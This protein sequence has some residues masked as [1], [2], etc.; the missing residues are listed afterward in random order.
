MAAAGRRET[1]PH[2]DPAESPY[3]LVQH[4]VGDS[5]CSAPPDSR[6]EWRRQPD[7]E[8]RM[9]TAERPRSDARHRPDSPSGC[10]TRPCD[11]RTSSPSSCS[12]W[13]LAMLVLVT[14]LECPWLGRASS[15]AVRGWRQG[16]RSNRAALQGHRRTG[17]Y[18]QLS[19]SLMLVGI[20]FGL[21][22]TILLRMIQPACCS[23][24]TK[25]FWR[26]EAGC[27]RPAPLR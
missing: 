16:R 22:Q 12:R 1:R 11:L 8:D 23:R 17:R 24:N 5:E 25:P 13:G 6:P 19:R 7:R 4:T 14:L 3:W 9:M 2:R 21:A 27:L 10:P 18:R 26:H 20:G 15:G